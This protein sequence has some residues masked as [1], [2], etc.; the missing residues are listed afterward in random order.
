MPMCRRLRAC[1]L[2][3]A[4]ACGPAGS[5]SPAERSTLIEVEGVEVTCSMQLGEAERVLAVRAPRV[6]ADRPCEVEVLVFRDAEVEIPVVF[7]RLRDEVLASTRAEGDPPGFDLADIEARWAAGD[8]ISMQTRLWTGDGEPAVI[9]E[10]I[11][12][13]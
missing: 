2:A 3:A 8:R 11:S 1:A 13:E 10:S 7:D 5:G 6:T 4:V 9:A 12:W